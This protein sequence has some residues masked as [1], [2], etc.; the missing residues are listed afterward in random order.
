MN[1]VYADRAKE[2]IRQGF[3]PVPM[4]GKAT[5][6][7]GWEQLRNP[8]CEQID[9]WERAGYFRNIGILLGE[10]SGNVVVLDFD[11][12]PAYDLFKEKFPDLADTFTV[13]SG[14]GNGMHCYFRVDLL[15]ENFDAKGIQIGDEIVD[16]ECRSNGRTIV[17]PPSIH[18]DTHRQYEVEKRTQIKKL[19]DMSAILAWMK[20]LIPEWEA[21]NV[22][23][24]T[25]A[26]DL[27][28][29]LLEAVERHFTSQPHKIHGVWIN[30]N[31]PNASAHKHGDKVSSFGYNVASACGHCFRCGVMNLRALLPYINI[32]P[33]EYGGFYERT[34]SYPQR[35][36]HREM[37]YDV[38]QATVQPAP[39][40]K[41]L[42][43][44]TRN[45][46]FTGYLNN[47][48]DYDT[49]RVD[50][51]VVFPFK[52]LHHL[53]GMCRVGRRGK[54]IGVIGVS[55]GGKTSYLETM[56]DGYLMLNVPVL[57]WSPEWTKEEM[58]ERSVQRYGGA[59]MEDVYLHEVH[60]AE[61]QQGIKH[62]AG[63]EMPLAMQ[64]RCVETIKKLR[65]WETQVGYIDEPYLNIH[66]F[67]EAIGAT[68][69]SL[70]FRPGV[71]V[72]DY[73]QLLAALDS[74]TNGSMYRLNMQLKQSCI[75]H[76]MQGVLASQSTK[77]STRNQ[78]NGKALDATAAQFVRDDAFNLFI[79]IN[80]DRDA[81]GKFMQSSVLNVAKNSYGMKGKVRV[82]TN[83]ERLAFADEMHPNQNFGEDEES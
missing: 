47:L 31:C 78:A 50:T 1:N 64:Q 36:E 8:D 16:I 45:S 44:V 30:T 63:V 12:M 3:T 24:P 73:L 74:E 20:T 35:P 55:G 70:D 4:T 13:R 69:E 81:D 27:N 2:M 41:V 7:K 62:G 56:I 59:R 79:T 22:A 80:P 53:G 26:G 42:N 19:T 32:D 75:A 21:P 28:P 58:V 23:L 72:M 18:P 49:P 17:I 76:K 37:Q 34:E 11:G 61:Y 68:L 52:A 6:L 66:Q 48:Q 5:Y 67:N 60:I 83:W 71:I 9:E 25:R 43:I 39:A 10:A 57:V 33:K 14:S 51:P 65:Q 15:P 29:K 77:E 38:Q 40:P 54:L 46:L 82:P